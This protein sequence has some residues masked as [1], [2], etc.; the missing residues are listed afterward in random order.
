[1]KNLALA[2]GDREA[3]SID[4]NTVTDPHLLKG[5]RRFDTDNGPSG[6]GLDLGNHPDVFNQPGKHSAHLPL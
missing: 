2:G 3:G 4:G 5:E 6:T 1:M